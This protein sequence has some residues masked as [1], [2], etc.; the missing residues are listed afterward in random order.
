MKTLLTIFTP[1]FIVMFSST[2][3]TSPSF[4]DDF[5][6][7]SSLLADHDVRITDSILA[8]HSVRITSSPSADHTV[9][10]PS[11]SNQKEIE[12]YVAAIIAVAA[13]LKK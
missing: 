3:F 12:E 1:I 4:G 7:S 6:I 13:S 2:S 8:D 9:C 5:T 11:G 10:V